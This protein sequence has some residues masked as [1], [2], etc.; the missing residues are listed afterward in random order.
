[1]SNF[2]Q[3][4]FS[5]AFLVVIVLITIAVMA[6]LTYVYRI[7][8]KLRRLFILAWLILFLLHFIGLV[9]VY[10]SV[11]QAQNRMI[12]ILNILSDHFILEFPVDYATIPHNISRDDPLYLEA[13]D[14]IQH[15]QD[16]VDWIAAV[17]TFQEKQD[18][19]FVLVLSPAADLN[20][21]NKLDLNDPSEMPDP[22][23]TPFR[24][25][26]SSVVSKIKRIFHEGEGG[27]TEP[28]SDHWGRWISIFRP[29]YN[30]DGNVCAIFAIDFWGN[31]W[32]QAFFFARVWPTLFYESFLIYFFFQFGLFLK[33][34]T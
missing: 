25:D 34:R 24:P 28:Y 14:H 26:S 33:H 32:E 4:F 21:D 29:L 15:L 8:A 18:G 5:T 9:C 16:E 17:Y 11:N 10:T 12:Q 7:E 20:R 6:V 2:L 30:S 23:G 31:D 19:N 1:M 3:I 27:I 22:P 13:L